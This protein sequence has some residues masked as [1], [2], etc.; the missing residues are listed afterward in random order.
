ML[1]WLKGFALGIIALC[2][3]EI[4]YIGLAYGGKE[5]DRILLH[6]K[7]FSPENINQWIEEHKNDDVYKRKQHP[8]KCWQHCTNCFYDLYDTTKE[9]S[10]YVRI[11]NSL[12]EWPA[13]TFMF[14]GKNVGLSLLAIKSTATGSLEQLTPIQIA[15]IAITG[16]A[17]ERFIADLMQESTRLS[18]TRLQEKMNNTVKYYNINLHL[19]IKGLK[20]DNK[21]KEIFLKN[22]QEIERAKAGRKES[23]VEENKNEI[24][25]E[26]KDIENIES[27]NI[28]LEKEERAIDA[29]EILQCA[30]EAYL[31]N[32][33]RYDPPGGAD[34][35]WWGFSKFAGTIG[36][37]C[38]W[39]Q[40]PV[41]GSTSYIL[42]ALNMLEAQAPG[43]IAP[44]S[45]QKAVLA[46]AL[47]IVPNLQTLMGAA[48]KFCTTKEHEYKKNYLDLCT[49][50]LTESGKALEFYNKL[51]E[52]IRDAYK[53]E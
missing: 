34:N 29:D 5:E 19:V 2:C 16:N 14:L 52:K 49:K 4:S 6:K 26:L 25:I 46:G 18:H 32:H 40:G 30:I 43:S 10:G 53:E 22:I 20:K 38:R 1:L 33:P 11:L 35:C 3:V 23:L 50:E 36:S 47:I 24:V 37:V 31:I 15:I 13:A 28:G 21:Q 45:T 27:K 41:L 42:M 17:F 8:E 48:V 7:L 12:L 44:T 39:V 51:Q 9:R